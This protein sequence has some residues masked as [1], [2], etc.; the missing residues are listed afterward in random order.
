MADPVN[1]LPPKL[2]SC[3]LT[4][5][6]T[7]PVASYWGGTSST[8]IYAKARSWN[9]VVSVNAQL[10]S[11]ASGMLGYGY[12]GTDVNVGDYITTDGGA[13]FLRIVSISAQNIGA[14][15]GVV[16]DED[17][18]NALTDPSQLGDGFIPDSE[19][20][21]FEVKNNMPVLFP[22]PAV[23]P[24]QFTRGFAGEIVSRFMARGK[25]DTFQTVQ[26][27]HDLVIGRA[28][29]LKTNGEFE[30]IDYTSTTSNKQVF[31]IVE[32]VHF[33]TSDF[34]R[35]RTVGPV[36][37]VNLTTGT[38]G[39]VFYLDRAS[40]AG[41]LTTTQPSKQSLPVYIKI[42]NTR[43]VFMASGLDE[44][45]DKATS[46]YAV[47]TMAELLAITTME[48]G[49][50]GYVIDMEDPEGQG[51][52]GYFI[53]DGSAWVMVSTEDGAG[54]DAKSFKQIVQWNGAAQTI[55]HRVSHNVRVLNVSVE[56]IVAFDGTGA[57]ITVGDAGDND[58]FMEVSENDLHS[59]GKYYSFPNH[60][61]NEAT[62]QE[63]IAFLTPGSASQGTAEVL[64]TYV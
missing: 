29:C 17:K 32:E 28:V 30:M 55:I 9:V 15:I 61:Y 18:Q 54:I 10:H 44:A 16:E 50:T 43:A 20:F 25:H 4:L 11:S 51:E 57:S 40:S 22:L 59:V 37:D 42:D 56:L 21:I 46:S 6:Q 34:V 8:D 1:V 45:V 49:D 23:L 19:G 26:A 3:S 27:G 36:I 38:A 48:T 64:I 62:E 39:S 12:T 31:G 41:Q 24:A 2:L 58:R 5:D 52:W 60:L 35:I 13:R 63:V 14:V 53:Y 33:P 7:N 47:A